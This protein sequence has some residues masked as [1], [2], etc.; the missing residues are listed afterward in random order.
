MG[1]S[2]TVYPFAGLRQLVP[3]SC[4]RVFINLDPVS[5]I[6]SRSD[7]VFIQMP[8]DEAV[9]LICDEIGDGWREEL[10]RLWKETENSYTPREPSEATEPSSKVPKG[11]YQ[12]LEDEVARMA[13]MI[14]E[15]MKLEENAEASDGE[16][17]SAGLDPNIS[18]QAV[19]DDDEDSDEEDD[20]PTAPTEQKEHPSTEAPHYQHGELSVPETHHVEEKKPKSEPESKV[21]KN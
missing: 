7:D 6:G 20:K 10:E 11:K 8:C 4:P 5:D 19:R 14:E 17:A 15:R 9:R 2:L 12:G 21:D 3:Q 13:K 16:A 18:I 1:T